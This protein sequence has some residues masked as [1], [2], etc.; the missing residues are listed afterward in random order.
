VRGL[1][2]TFEGPEGAGKTTQVELLRQALGERSPVITREPGGTPLGERLRE[3]LLHSDLDL[4]AQAEMLLFMA[5]RAE[6]LGRVIEPALAAGRIVI[7]DR[8]HDSTLAYQG[9]G[10]GAPGWWPEWFPRPDRTFLLELS[11]EL[12]LARLGGRGRRA[13]RLESEALE[14]HCAVAR[15]YSRLADEDP[16]RFVR[17]DATLPPAVIHE[18]VM[19]E[20][21]HLLAP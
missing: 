18:A 5:A 7:A 10:R 9:G 2:I 20:L 17:L 13:D 8:Y 12:G 1:F 19:A 15:A 21:S 3:L 14:F 4:T 6:L 16:S 11:P